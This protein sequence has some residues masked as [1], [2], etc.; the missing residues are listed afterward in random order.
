MPLF[1]RSE[2]GRHLKGWRKR[3]KFSAWA[4]LTAIVLGT[5]PA[6]AE[7]L[8]L[9]TTRSL[10]EL[11]AELSARD[12]SVGLNAAALGAVS[13][14]QAIEVT[15][16]ERYR[17]DAAVGGNMVDIPV[18][19]LPVPP[20]PAP[21]PFQP[22]LIS[23]L[24]SQVAIDME[25]A[26]GHLRMAELGPSDRL[27]IDVAALWFDIDADGK[28]GAGEGIL[29]VAGVVVSTGMRQAAPPPPVD[30]LIVH[31]DAADVEWLVA[32]THLLSAVSEF[33]LAFDPSEVIAE[34]MESNA[35]FD[36]VAES[37]FV[38][39]Y[40]WLREEAGFIDTFA[41]VYGAL[42]RVPDKERIAAARDHLLAMIE[43][44]REFWKLI[45][46]ETDNSQEWIPNA[47]QQAALG[48]S[49]PPNTG[50]IWMGVL[51]DAEAVLQGKLLV[52]HW[53]SN[54]GGG[55]NVAKLV[56]DPPAFDI[57]TWF[58]G[59]GL[60]PYIEKGPLVS[61]ESYARFE[62]MFRGDAMLFVVLLN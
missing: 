42:N 61:W 56:A 6:L 47:K 27:I 44:N 15:L 11:K 28:R 20:N 9:D 48:F 34:I 30:G 22:E 18:L 13:F 3:G 24:F 1:I 5:N 14:L 17:S 19:R 7:D 10:T 57:V 58:Q 59:S 25:D 21:Q 43:R 45:A 29:E 46:L 4:C 16:Q 41:V 53:R 23:A 33:V 50:S 54:P 36:E 52:S 38:N 2:I 31:F 60:A 39:E 40:D 51:A 35:V 12:A 49:L 26:R 55:V 37:F 32:Y 8:T 62:A